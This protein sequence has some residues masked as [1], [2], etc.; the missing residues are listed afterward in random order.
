MSRLRIFNKMICLT[1]CLS[2][3]TA[4]NGAAGSAG[5]QSTATFGPAVQT[6]LAEAQRPRPTQTP[7]PD[8][9]ATS[10]PLP[11]A[12]STPA[13]PTAT[14]GPTSTPEPDKADEILLQALLEPTNFDSEWWV[15]EAY[16]YEDNTQNRSGDDGMLHSP[17]T[18]L[19]CGTSVADPY[20]NQ[21]STYYGQDEMDWLVVHFV[22]LYPSEQHA[23]LYASQLISLLQNCQEFE[24]EYAGGIETTRISHLDYPELGDRSAAF[25]LVSTGDGYQVEAVLSVFRVGRTVSLILHVGESATSGPVEAWG[26]NNITV[27]AFEKVVSLREQ[28]DALERPAPNVV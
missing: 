12:T 26:T 16:I 1:L 22:A 10:T 11:T 8:P 5:P 4:C 28:I 25:V 19:Y 9:L 2:I 24:E 13:P 21:V 6:R 3:L 23:D 7:T 15:D 27:S 14:P 20:T 17:Q 18:D